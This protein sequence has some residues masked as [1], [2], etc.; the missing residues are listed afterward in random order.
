M[1]VKRS[2]VVLFY[3][4]FF[5]E[6]ELLSS[7][8]ELVFLKFQFQSMNSMLPNTMLGFCQNISRGNELHS[9]T[10]AFSTRDS[11]TCPRRVVNAC[12]D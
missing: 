7:D 11:F 4:N 2:S 3:V 6:L 10:R 9:F 5:L 1:T 8:F 12:G